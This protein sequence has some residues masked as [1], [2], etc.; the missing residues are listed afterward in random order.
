[1]KEGVVGV[2]SLPMGFPTK[3]GFL[4]GNRRFPG[5]GGVRGNRRFPG[6]EYI[7]NAEDLKIKFVYLS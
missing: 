6:K 7:Y 4:Q 1:M 2:E 5:R 3:G